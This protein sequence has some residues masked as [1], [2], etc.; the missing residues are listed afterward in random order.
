VFWV[1][2]APASAQKTITVPLQADAW[3]TEDQ[4]VEFTTYRGEPALRSYDRQGNTG[5]SVLSVRGLDFTDGTIE[6]DVAFTDSTRFTTCY[7]RLRDGENTEHVY[8]R[9]GFVG[10]PN[11]MAAVQYAATV[12]GVNYWDL[13]PHYQ[14]SADLSGNGEWNHVKIVVRDRQLLAYVNDMDRPALY[15]PVLDGEVES[16]GV[17]VDGNVYL[18]NLQVTPGHTPGLGAGAGYDPVHNDPRYLR[19]WEASLP[20]SL[21]FGR[22]PGETDM[23]TDT[24]AWQPITAEHHGTINLSRPYGGTSYDGRRRLAWLRTTITAGREQER[25]LDLGFTDEVYVYLN[26]RPL[27]TA[28]N[29]F[30]S[31]GQLP[32]G[33]RMSI[34]N[35]RIRLPLR[36]G[37]NEI[38]VGLTNYFYGWGLVARLDDGSGLKY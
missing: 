37:E 4:R 3:N 32:P 22:E 20:R 36:E 5:N 35:S 24:T 2:S 14:S 17:G 7:F 23:P 13:S 1:I 38:L 34:E 27:Y 9:A 29:Q 10:N 31:P 15:V 26:E 8:L 25:Y 12:D 11:G 28:K 16:G 19:M 18:A 33:G 21:P 30:G 6:Y